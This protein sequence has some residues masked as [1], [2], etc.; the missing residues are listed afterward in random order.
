MILYLILIAHFFA[1]F[2]LQS[3]SWAEKKTKKFR[4]LVGHAVTYAAVVVAALLTSVSISS[5]WCPLGLISVS[6]FLIDW[7]RI[8]VDKKYNTPTI[9]FLSFLIDQVL[10]ISIIFI[11]VYGWQL[12]M[13]RAS[14]IV[15]LAE[16]I[17]IEQIL[18]YA[19]IFVVILD[20]ASV[21]IKKLTLYATGSVQGAGKKEPPVGS[22]IGK[23]E[24]LIIVILVICNQ[25]GAIGFVLTAKSLARYKQLDNQSFAE[26]YLVGTLGSTAI[27]IITA[28]LL[29]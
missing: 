1:D 5:V 14:W 20:P 25:I 27:A 8:F 13:H 26:K 22:V 3:A 21:C 4:Y 10:H 11:A 24:R 9:S 7:I 12:E 15:A 19:L 18:R 6:H 16:Q 28:L 2:T 23:L 17:T 29:K